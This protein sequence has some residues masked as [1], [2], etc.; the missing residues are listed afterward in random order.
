M[1][2]NRKYARVLEARDVLPINSSDKKQKQQIGVE[3][4]PGPAILLHERSEVCV[5]A[6]SACIF[7]ETT[8]P[9]SASILNTL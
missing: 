1:I 7:I 5:H 4:Y 8:S 2:F 9:V 6:A 3:E